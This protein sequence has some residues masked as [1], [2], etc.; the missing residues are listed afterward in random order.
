MSDEMPE[1][2]GMQHPVVCLPYDPLTLPRVPKTIRY[3]DDY[4]NGM[5]RI[6]SAATADTWSFEFGGRSH[7]I[8]FRPYEDTL[9]ALCRSWA[10]WTLESISPSTA[11]FYLGAVGNIG[12]EFRE[13]VASLLSPPHEAQSFWN[14]HVVG[15]QLS[16]G[17]RTALKCMLRFFCDSSVGNWSPD[18]RLFVDAM[19]LGHLEKCRD[20]SAVW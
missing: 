7:K 11:A 20:L 8:N 6:P 10:W 4:S 5:R 9:G 15:G 16:L 2:E 17:Q 14:L 19:P 3:H 1:N 13:I 18:Y 12:A